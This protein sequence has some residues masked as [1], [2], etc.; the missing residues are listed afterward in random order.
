MVMPKLIPIKA[1]TI[2][3]EIEGTK[4][5]NSKPDSKSSIIVISISD[6]FGKVRDDITPVV[7][8]SSNIVIIIKKT[9]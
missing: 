9:K 8:P 7:V 3:L 2:S 6:G 5:L 4:C 1:P